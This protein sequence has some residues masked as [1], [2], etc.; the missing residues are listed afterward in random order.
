MSLILWWV[1]SIV[2]G[3]VAHESRH[4][5]CGRIGSIPIH[6]MVIGSGPVLMH[7]R[8][9]E[10][11]LELRRWPLGG[12]VM[13]VAFR[14]VGKCRLA[15]FYLGGVLGNIAVIGAIAWI[16]VTGTAPA[17]LR[18]IGGPAVFAQV[19]IILTT[20]IPY[21]TRVEGRP[22]ASD[23]L[24]LLRL[25]FGLRKSAYVVA[26]LE[27]YHS[28]KTRPP[29]ASPVWSRIAQQLGRDRWANEDVRSDVQE[30]LRRE[31]AQGG[32]S[33]EEELLVLDVLVTDGLVF[34][35]PVLRPKLDEWSLRA[36]WLGPAS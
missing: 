17:V 11:R 28:D 21:R 26:A 4:L 13:P 23:G 6:R 15:L 12:F 24:Q 33:P 36:L 32:L 22:G 1:L 20:L 31:L 29:M 34:A 14:Y 35:D 3:T 18:E 25:L 2:V 8:I 19:C 9:G 5:L 30:A 10:L 7:W 16:D 27:C